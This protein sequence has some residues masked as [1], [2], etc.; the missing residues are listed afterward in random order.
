[1]RNYFRVPKRSRRV[2]VRGGTANRGKPSLP[3]VPV[4]LG[5]PETLSE[6]D[7]LVFYGDRRDEAHHA[8]GRLPLQ[9]DQTNED[10]SSRFS[11]R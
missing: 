2:Q 6:A 11:S 3:S 7:S 4:A 9:R 10:S 5:A 8:S 1:M